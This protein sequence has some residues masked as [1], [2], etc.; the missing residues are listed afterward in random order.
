MCLVADLSQINKV[1]VTKP[2]TKYQM[3]SEMFSQFEVQLT[4]NF[5]TIKPKAQLILLKSAT[6]WI[7]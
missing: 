2:L 6:N 3:F 4:A 1:I 7:T 5:K